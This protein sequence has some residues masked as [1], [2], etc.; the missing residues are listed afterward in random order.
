M[1][2]PR[3]NQAAHQ[4]ERCGWYR[5]SCKSFPGFWFYSMKLS[6]HRVWPV[7]FCPN[8]YVCASY[9]GYI[10]IHELKG[11]FGSPIHHVTFVHT[12]SSWFCQNRY[13][14][15]GS[16]YEATNLWSFFILLINAA[17]LDPRYSSPRNF[18]CLFHSSSAGASMFSLFLFVAMAHHFGSC[19]RFRFK[20]WTG[21]ESWL[22]CISWKDES[23]EEAMS[24]IVSGWASHCYKG[25]RGSTRPWS[26][27]IVASC[28]Y[29][30]LSDSYQP[31]CLSPWIPILRQSKFSVRNHSKEL[32]ANSLSNRPALSK[33]Y[34]GIVG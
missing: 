24:I 22:Y 11:S 7:C 20:C 32:L 25:C 13:I 17:R 2:F 10:P 21:E 28:S 9:A 18:L 19:A 30:L 33:S 8:H 16:T 23:C 26:S 6:N 31:P 12:Y 4:S 15:W 29:W 5:T 34:L 3:K 1:D 27:S 14:L